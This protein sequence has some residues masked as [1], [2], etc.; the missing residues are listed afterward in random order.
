M[1]E[2]NKTTPK[3]ELTLV[4]KKGVTSET[5]ST[6]RYGLPGMSYGVCPEWHLLKAIKSKHLG[7]EYSHLQE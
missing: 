4:D 5:Y 1:Q 2:R 7:L 3:V 6:S